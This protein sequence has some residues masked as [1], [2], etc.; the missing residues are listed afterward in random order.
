[1]LRPHSICRLL[2]MHVVALRCHR[3]V[4]DEGLLM[5]CLAAFGNR[6]NMAEAYHRQNHLGD[7]SKGILHALS[8]GLRPCF[9]SK[10]LCSLPFQD[11]PCRCD[12]VGSES[13]PEQQYKRK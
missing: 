7:A 5:I 9:L 3:N 2:M 6:L 4:A 10:R 8:G 13:C 1:M 12:R 11:A